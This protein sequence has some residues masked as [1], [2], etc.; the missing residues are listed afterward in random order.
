MIW[1]PVKAWRFW[2]IKKLA[3]KAV[4]DALVA[5]EEPP[6]NFFGVPWSAPDPQSISKAEDMID[7]VAI[8]LNE[9]DKRREFLEASQKFLYKRLRK[10]RRKQ[11]EA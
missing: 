5:H 11:R 3:K 4:I 6:F 1:N 2:K 10:L 8:E 7:Q 9:I